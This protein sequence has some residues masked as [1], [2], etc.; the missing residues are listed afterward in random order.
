MKIIAPENGG[1][2][3][4]SRGWIRVWLTGDD[5]AEGP[6]TDIWTRSDEIY[7]LKVAA[8]ELLQLPPDEIS[9]LSSE[10]GGYRRARAFDEGEGP[11]AVDAGNIGFYAGGTGEILVDG[12]AQHMAIGDFYAGEVASVEFVGFNFFSVI[13]PA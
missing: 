6:G 12:V 8:Y 13:W 10:L 9:F 2:T 4:T 5:L 1:F 11:L 3:V 7:H